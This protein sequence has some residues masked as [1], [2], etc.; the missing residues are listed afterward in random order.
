MKQ[1]SHHSKFQ[2]QNGF[3]L[4][5]IMVAMTLGLILM[6][7]V[8]SLITTN[9]MTYRLTDNM[10][11]VQENA[12]FLQN[13]LNKDLRMVGYKGCATRQNITITNTLNDSSDLAYNFSD[14]GLVGYDNVSAALPTDLNSYLTGDPKPLKG[15]DVIIIRAPSG[16]N[17]SIIKNNDAARLLAASTASS[18]FSDGD[19]VMVSDCEKARIFQITNLQTTGNGVNIVHSKNAGNVTPG[20]TVSSWDPPASEDSFGSDASLVAYET[21]A[22][23]IANNP[24]TAIPTLYKKTNANEA[25]PL[26]NGVYG[27][28]VRYGEDT[29]GDSQVNAYRTASAVS[30][31]NNI[32][33]INIEAILGTDDTSLV[34]SPQSL[35]FNQSTFNATDTRWY[36]TKQIVSTLR[37]RIN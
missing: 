9:N 27:F 5:E 22:Y 18:A 34:T 36:M 4:V 21:T 15:S 3:S 17:I 2:Y 23:F 8:T 31:W 14:D 33:T 11:K 1:I 37:N 29:D 6:L 28:Q 7:G 35:S 12:R 19:I 32:I 30:S 26:I 25:L 13:M 20:N 10:G 24:T 16:D